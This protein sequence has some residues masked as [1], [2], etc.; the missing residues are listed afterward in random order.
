[1]DQLLIDAVDAGVAL[2]GWWDVDTPRVL[3][4]VRRWHDL[5]V[6]VNEPPQRPPGA[7]RR[8]SPLTR[9]IDDRHVSCRV[10]SWPCRPCWG[11]RAASLSFCIL[12]VLVVALSLET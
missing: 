1:V 2:V 5:L 12:V 8:G 4:A 11:I 10:V 3:G 6:A 7:E 9:H